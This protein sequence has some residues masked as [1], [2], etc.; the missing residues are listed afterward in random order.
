M[1]KRARAARTMALATRVV[2]NKEGNGNYSKSNDDEGDRQAMV[3]RV[4]AMVKANTWA[5]LMVKRLTGNKEGKGDGGKGNGN[6]TE[7]GGRQIGH[8]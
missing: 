7:G 1:S 4:M 6:G 8:R 5:I 3:T 2:C